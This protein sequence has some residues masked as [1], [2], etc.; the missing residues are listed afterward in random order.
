MLGERITFNT[1]ELK[2]PATVNTKVGEIAVPA[3]LVV[4]LSGTRLKG[5]PEER[6]EYQYIT[7]FGAESIKRL[8][9]YFDL[10]QPG[11]TVDPASPV[12]FAT[13]I[14]GY[15]PNKNGR[16]RPEAEFE[17]TYGLTDVSQGTYMITGK[18]WGVSV[19]G[20][21]A[22]LALSCSGDAVMGT[23]LTVNTDGN[24]IF[25]TPDE[26]CQAVSEQTSIPA[27]LQLAKPVYPKTPALANL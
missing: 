20:E 23:S 9:K 5:T 15:Q 12:E 27:M 18:L 4:A 22:T 26:L 1:I 2:D 8:K 16:P 6:N 10:Y 25:V 14:C 11:N 3:A 21:L 7:E 24:L 17:M 19:A 13:F